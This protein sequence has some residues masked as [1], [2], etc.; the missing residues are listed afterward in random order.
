MTVVA[1]SAGQDPLPWQAPTVSEAPATTDSDES[2]LFSFGSDQDALRAADLA[3]SDKPLIPEPESIK[4]A[5]KG[6]DDAGSGLF[7]FA[8]DTDSAS[9]A[10]SKDVIDESQSDSGYSLGLGDP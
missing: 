6:E 8:S 2:S 4:D 1:A 10:A 9:K 7:S 3:S 5:E